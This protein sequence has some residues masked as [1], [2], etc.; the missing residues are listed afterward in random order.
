MPTLPHGPRIAVVGA[1]IGG[2]AV[3]GGNGWI[4][5]YDA[6]KALAMPS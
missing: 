1:G 4:Y 3:A 2:L 6:E 5:G